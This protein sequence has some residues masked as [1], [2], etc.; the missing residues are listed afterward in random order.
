[1]LLCL[2]LLRLL[3]LRLRLLTRLLLRLLLRRGWSVRRWD[4]G[5]ERIRLLLRVLLPLRGRE[6][7][8]GGRMRRLRVRA[9]PPAAAHHV[10]WHGARR[11]PEDG[12]PSRGLAAG[13]GVDAGAV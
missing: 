9:R 7:V 13:G 8:R 3:L 5:G 4:G 11:P 2:L 1:M 6:A 12:L 10:V